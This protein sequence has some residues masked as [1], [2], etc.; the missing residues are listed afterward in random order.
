MTQPNIFISCK[1]SRIESNRSF[2]GCFYLGPFDSGQSLTVANALRRT[3]ISECPGLG[4][5]SVT[6]ENVT[7]EYSTIPGM[8]ESVLDLLLN[9]KEIVLKKRNKA[10]SLYK[11]NSMIYD[12][13]GTS[14][15][16]PVSGFLKVKGPGV[17]RAKDLKLPPFLECVDPQ[18][19][20]ATLADDGLLCMKFIIMEGKGYLIPNFSSH[21]SSL[22]SS[23]EEIKR[24]GSLGGSK[25]SSHL[26][27]IDN[28]LV[29]KR[30]NFLNEIKNYKQSDSST[31]TARLERAGGMKQQPGYKSNA[32]TKAEP[33]TSAEQENTNSY[34]NLDTV[35][36]P[37]TKV[38]YIIEDFENKIVDDSNKKL[39]F[40]DEV[41]T[42][43]ESSHYLKNNIPFLTS[44]TAIASINQK[45]EGLLSH[46]VLNGRSAKTTEAQIS[47]FVDA[48][49]TSEINKLSSTLHPLKKQSSLHTII[50]EIWTNGSLH[51]RD[52]LYMA[53]EKLASLFLNMKK[54]Q[55][56]NSIYV[57][58]SSML[59]HG[60]DPS[61]RKDKDKEAVISLSKSNKTALALASQPALWEGKEKRATQP[62]LLP[63]LE[64]GEGRKKG[65][66][67]GELTS[68]NEQENYD[69][70][71]LNIPLRPYTLLK[72][73]NI[74]TISDLCLLT[75]ND[76]KYICGF[77]SK[78]VSNIVNILAKN[79]FSLKK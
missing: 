53:F 24:D 59:I 34:I 12:Q 48:Y 73:S 10:Y 6:I 26:S 43:I 60:P 36:N 33:K 61:H 9:I 74:N 72:R 18:Q 17:I 25:K 14:Y 13:I 70:D 62:N 66:L 67:K 56:Y 39:N 41:S 75:I 35:F 32:I 31:S 42:L 38:S 40:V 64:T 27:F 54:T 57:N 63:H 7:H 15:L 28:Q 1:E 19:Y 11:K 71:Y 76:L 37:V 45:E 49:S 78:Y 23:K 46:S 69:I 47:N 8:R 29:K 5:V 20:I 44:A 30:L 52:A 58:E 51:P 65:N 22:M 77:N 4:I 21:S 50:L 16:K 2:Y 68:L 79:G 3:L 55:C